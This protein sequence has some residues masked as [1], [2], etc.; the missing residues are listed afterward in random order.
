MHAWEIGTFG[1]ASKVVPMGMVGAGTDSFSGISID[2][3]YQYIGDTVTARLDWMHESHNSSA[4]QTLGLA[5]NSN[6]QLR[7]FECLSLI[8]MTRRGATAG[9]I[10]VSAMQTQRF[11]APLPEARTAPDGSSSLLICRSTAAAQRFGHG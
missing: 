6:N 8:F 4:G 7:S 10:S 1:L 3:Q 2:T 9:L 5:D 11:T